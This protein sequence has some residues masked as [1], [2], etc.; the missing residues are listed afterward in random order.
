MASSMSSSFAS[1]RMAD[2]VLT[3]DHVTMR[4]GGLV[5]VN[6]LSFRVGRG[7]ITALIGPNGAGKT[8]CFNLLT[9]FLEP[10]RGSIH[11]NGVDV[12]EFVS[13]KFEA[14]LCHATQLPE[15][16]AMRHRVAEWM[17]ATGR[18]FGLPEGRSAEAVRVV[19]TG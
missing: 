6:D 13:Q 14:L 15:P 11:F 12:T 2:P 4:F 19:Q 5:A 8:T 17:V 1:P 18:A 10:T 16:D 3:V 9:K 7:D